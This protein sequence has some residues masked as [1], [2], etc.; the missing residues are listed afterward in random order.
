MI[1]FES[2]S[3]GIIGPV[4]DRLGGF[5]ECSFETNRDFVV[6]MNRRAIANELN[7]D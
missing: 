1:N 5:G 4:N 3:D 2:R 6:A 7:S